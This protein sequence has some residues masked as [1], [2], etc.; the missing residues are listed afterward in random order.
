MNVLVLGGNGFIGSNLCQELLKQNHN[1]R[2]LDRSIKNNN[3]HYLSNVEFIEID[4]VQ[5][6]DF[7]PYLK[8]IDVVFHLI[9]T[10]IPSTSNENKIFDIKTNVCPTLQL[11]EDIVKTGHIKIVFLSSGGTVYG[12]TH[13]EVIPEEHPLNPICSYGIQKLTIEKYLHFYNHEY[14]LDYCTVR[15]SN[16]YGRGQD[17][18]KGQ[19]VIPIFL[20]KILKEEEIQIWG[21]GLTTRDYIYIDD[22]VDA[23]C[24]LLNY[25]GQQKVFNLGSGI[26]HTLL[27][28]IEAISME[29]MRKA[30]IQYSDARSIDVKRNVLDITRIER[31]LLWKPEVSLNEG[32]HK[33]LLFE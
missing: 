24:K 23:L 16:P 27:D 10:T 11:L 1:V 13:L 22:V 15:L 19:G 21:D 26:G 20:N 12:D 4:Y 28:I 8:G 32:I 18:R 25:S 7:T 3:I 29:T 30:H 33:I 2:I 9:S 31:E 14:G 5:T 6:E 17:G